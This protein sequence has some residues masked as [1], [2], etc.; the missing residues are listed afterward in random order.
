MPEETGQ[1]RVEATVDAPVASVWH[2][3]TT[4]QGAET[5]FAEKANI[6]LQLGGAYEIFFNPADERMS[7]KG[8]KVLSY[9]PERMVSFEWNLPLDQFP[10]LK[11]NLTWFVVDFT[12]LDS[13]RT[14]VTVTQLGLK[15][16]P[17]WERAARHMQQGWSEL[18][19]RLKARFDS[20]PI[21]WAH[22]RMMWQARKA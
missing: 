11:D 15:R 13:S 5:F 14:R 10:E 7:T 21:D 3:W 18:A 12:S 4:S 1:V 6:D 17:V 9:E 2:A 20:G 19:E 16:G 22:Q 8:R